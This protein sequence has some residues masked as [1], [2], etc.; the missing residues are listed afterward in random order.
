V[1]LST[2]NH[3][4]L[5]SFSPSILALN[6]VIVAVEIDDKNLLLD[7]AAKNTP[8]GTLPYNCLNGTGIL[9]KSQENTQT[10]SLAPAKNTKTTCMVNLI[11]NTDGI[12]QGDA[13]YYFTGYDAVQYRASYFD[14]Q[15]EK[16]YAK[17]VLSKNSSGLKVQKVEV[18]DAKE[19]SKPLTIK[20]EVADEEKLEGDVLYIEPFLSKV[21]GENPFTQESRKY[22]VDFAFPHQ[23]S[24]I[25]NFTIPQNY[26]VEELPKNEKIALPDN[27]GSFT[28]LVAQNDGKIQISCSFAINKTLFLGEEY[29]ILKEF[30]AKIIAKQA[31]QIVL[32]KVSN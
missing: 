25:L 11:I 28:C 20:I 6:H 24:Y 31:E 5:R 21:Y 27:A 10:I 32:K 18:K 17:E 1:V 16:E 13:T 19:I 2:R 9:I 23:E 4:Q 22:P 7:A 26:K 30:A 3:G 29:A 8:V 15:D 12:L 14:T